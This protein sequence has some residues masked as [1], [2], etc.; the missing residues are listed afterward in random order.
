MLDYLSRRLRSNL[1]VNSLGLPENRVP[2]SIHLFIIVFP[3][4]GPSMRGFIISIFRLAPISS[5]ISIIHWVTPCYTPIFHRWNPL[6][7]LSR[8]AAIPCRP[9]SCWSPICTPRRTQIVS[10]FSSPTWAGKNTLKVHLKHQ[11]A[12]GNPY[13][14]M[15]W[16]DLI[17]QK[18]PILAMN[19]WVGL[20]NVGEKRKVSSLSY[21]WKTEP[22]FGHSPL[23]G[24]GK[25]PFDIDKSKIPC[26]W[27]RPICSFSQ[28]ISHENLHLFHAIFQ[29]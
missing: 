3:S 19:R 8:R 21:C 18:V 12:N 24:E 25:S 16:A 14:W 13:V 29:P 26:S 4:E 22:V 7:W 9:C 23:L 6:S 27:D 2:H 20:K 11:F 10:A 15:V 1:V 28:W 17:N 5:L